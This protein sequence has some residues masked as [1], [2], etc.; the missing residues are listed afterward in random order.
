[1]R[2]ATRLRNRFPLQDITMTSREPKGF[3]PDWIALPVA[4]RFRAF[5][6]PT[7]EHRAAITKAD[8]RSNRGVRCAS[9]SV[10]AWLI[11]M[12]VMLRNL[13]NRRIADMMSPL[14]PKLCIDQHTG[15][16]RVDLSI[17]V[18]VMVQTGAVCGPLPVWSDG[19]WHIYKASRFTPML[20]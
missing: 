11:G 4:C 2:G 10:P 18:Y 7:Q 12:L 17:C 16:L 3:E 20:T 14:C 9:Q 19:M 8:F 6:R 15:L 1:M 5:T 13:G